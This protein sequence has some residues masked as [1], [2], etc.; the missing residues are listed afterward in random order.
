MQWRWRRRNNCCVAAT[1]QTNEVCARC[2]RVLGR[3]CRGKYARDPASKIVQHKDRQV[4]EVHVAS[5]PNV[6]YRVADNLAFY[7]MRLPALPGRRL[8]GIPPNAKRRRPQ[9]TQGRRLVVMLAGV[10]AAVISIANLC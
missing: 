6:D 9:C 7:R 8:M 10:E 1:N 5:L 4:S 3:F 2:V